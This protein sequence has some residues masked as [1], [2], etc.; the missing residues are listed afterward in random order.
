MAGETVPQPNSTTTY[1]QP[2]Y[3]SDTA[4]GVAGGV[5]G[6]LGD[7]GYLNNVMGNWYNQD[8]TQGALGQYAQFDPTKQQQFMNPYTQNVV[9]EQAR[10]SN[11]NLFENVLPQVNST[12]T[13]AGQFGSTRNA[14]FTNRAIRD[15]QQTLGGLQASTLMNAQNQAN[16]NYKDWTAQGVQAGQQD[17]TNWL[18]KA[19][20]P[21][22]ALGGLGQVTSNI[23][24]SNPLAVSTENAGLTD[25]DRINL[26]IRAAESGLGADGTGLDNILNMLGI[27][28]GSTN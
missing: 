11:Q 16:Q 23:R 28:T 6:M 27:G 4:A 10:L 15:Q 9:N 17:F 12:F 25:L 26:A 3:Y 20:F 14:D 1:T 19:N 13:G 5:Q 2:S 24:P 22:T 21:I 7:N 8:P 18:Q